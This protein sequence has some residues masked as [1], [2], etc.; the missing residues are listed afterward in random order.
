MLFNL[1]K[2]LHFYFKAF[3]FYQSTVYAQGW[4]KNE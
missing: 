1:N 4:G 3:M 2:F